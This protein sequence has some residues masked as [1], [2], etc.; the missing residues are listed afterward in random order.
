M[1]TETELLEFVSQSPRFVAE[2]DRA[3]WLGLFAADGVV[4]DPVGSRPHVGREA[5]GRFYD[6]FIGPNEVVFDVDHDI[7]CGTTVIRDLTLHTTMSTG[8]ELIVPMHLR[9]ELAVDAGRL[10][11]GGLF[12]HWELPSM[13]TQL[14]RCGGPGVRAALRLTP[15]LLSSQGVGGALG[16]AHGFRR[17]GGSQARTA[18][19]FLDA[20]AAGRREVAVAMASAAE[21]EY[22]EGQAVSIDELL[23]QVR[24]LRWR[25]M[26]RAGRSITVSVEVG[27]RPA[28]VV[29][30]CPVRRGIAAVRFYG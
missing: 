26:I 15:Q 5:I 24:G 3:S 25:K 6:T 9:Y 20:V 10:A 29:F 1:P 14:L 7:V 8:A 23:S 11:I 19:R 2:H 22:P 21:L 4:N 17:V 27:G 12:A 13:V 30:D 18:A 16:F 28:V